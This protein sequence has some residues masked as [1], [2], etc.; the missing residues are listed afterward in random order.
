MRNEEDGVLT[1]E[2]FRARIADN[3]DPEFV[4]AVVESHEVPVEVLLFLAEDDNP[5]IRYALAENHNVD[6]NVLQKLVD[7]ANP[8]VAWR[9][10]RTLL[11]LGME[12]SSL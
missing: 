11:R 12:M 9:A 4:I 8:Y 6:A 3:S 2:I 7:D 10:Q 1:L 5:D